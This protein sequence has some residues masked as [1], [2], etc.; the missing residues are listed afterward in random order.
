MLALA[1][2]KMSFGACDAVREGGPLQLSH[3]LMPSRDLGRVPTFRIQG[4][5]VVGIGDFH[6]H[7]QAIACAVDFQFRYPG[8]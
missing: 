8:P 5:R 4:C 2:Y 3:A 1:E 7:D 6:D